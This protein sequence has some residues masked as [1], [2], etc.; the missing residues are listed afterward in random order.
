MNIPEGWPTEEMIEAGVLEMLGRP[1]DKMMPV[2]ESVVGIFKAILQAAPIPPAQDGP[3]A[4]R[5]FDAKWGD[6]IYT[7]D[8]KSHPLYLHRQ[9]ESLYTAPPADKLR[10]AAE[11]VLKAFDTSSTDYRLIKSGMDNLRAALEGK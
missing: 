11:E 4:Y 9:W 5:T 8:C 3:V 7:G 6:Y 1:F 2:R 10:K